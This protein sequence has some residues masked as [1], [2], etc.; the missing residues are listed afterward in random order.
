MSW[1]VQEFFRKVAANTAK[2]V[3]LK[4]SADLQGFP[5]MAQKKRTQFRGPGG[6]PGG[7]GS[8]SRSKKAR[9]A[10][11]PALRRTGHNARY[12]EARGRHEIAL[13][14][15]KHQ[16][17]NSRASSST[18]RARPRE[19]LAQAVCLKPGY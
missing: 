4:E 16:G 7:G 5:Q 2:S 12:T 13:C 14:P 8:D 17:C 19:W 1:C 18:A 11:V 15:V 3:S 10:F 6:E 9:A